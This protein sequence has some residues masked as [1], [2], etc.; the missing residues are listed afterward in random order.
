MTEYEVVPLTCSLQDLNWSMNV[1]PIEHN[2]VQIVDVTMIS[3]S[4]YF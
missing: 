4:P 2:E 1:P 3:E